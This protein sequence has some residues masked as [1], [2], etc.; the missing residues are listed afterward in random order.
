MRLNEHRMLWVAVTDPT[1]RG[2][3]PLLL[4]PLDP[5]GARHWAMGQ[6]LCLARAH[7]QRTRN[8]AVPLVAIGSPTDAELSNQLAGF[9]DARIIMMRALLFD[10]GVELFGN[11]ERVVFSEHPRPQSAL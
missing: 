6:I 2:N 8:M 3:I 1:L 9:V 5:L 11:V 4:H 10:F 7:L